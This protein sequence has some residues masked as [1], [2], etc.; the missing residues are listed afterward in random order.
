MVVHQVFGLK[1][2]LQPSKMFKGFRKKGLGFLGTV[3]HLQSFCR[4]ADAF[5]T[6]YSWILTVALESLN[7]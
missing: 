2:I 1:R 7:G 4:L 6:L 5:T 3:D